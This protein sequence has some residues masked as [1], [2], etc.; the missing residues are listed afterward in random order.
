[1]VNLKINSQRNPT[2]P[3]LILEVFKFL[4]EDT[5]T[6][7]LRE[8]NIRDIEDLDV[9]KNQTIKLTFYA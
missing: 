9:S 7:I 3:S 6:K 1:M 2:N 8:N 5:K 4:D